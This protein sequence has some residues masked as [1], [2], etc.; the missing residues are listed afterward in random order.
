MSTAALLQA[1]RDRLRSQLGYAQDKCDVRPD[2]R[3]IPSA[4]DSYIA[5]HQ[6]GVR[7]GHAYSREEYYV[8]LVTISLKGSR[9]PF[10][11]WGQVNE[12]EAL[13][14]IEAFA[15]PIIDQLHGAG[16]NGIAI[17]TAANNIIGASSNGFITPLLFRQD[18]GGYGIKAADWWGAKEPD[19]F[20]GIA[21]VLRF[22]DALR[23]RPLS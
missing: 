7:G 16:T 9:A 21:K 20:A 18:S 5:V 11:R 12:L 17:L 14:N 1:V 10:D 3:P 19:Q 8:V 2:G 22:E 4:G 6:G 15:D 23:K 13:R